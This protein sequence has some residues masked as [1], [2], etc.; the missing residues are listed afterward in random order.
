MNTTVC[1]LANTL[2]Y[3]DGGGGHQWA[4]LNW[5][6]GLRAAGCRVIWMEAVRPDEP[7]HE[8]QALVAH[9]KGRLARYGLADTVA[10]CPWTSEPLL[11]G[12]VHGCLDLDDASEADLLLNLAPSVPAA[13]VGRFRRSAFLDIDPGLTQVWMAQ[14]LKV[15]RHSL[16]F[17][18][19]EGVGQPGALFPDHGL[20][21]H[22]TPPPVCLQAWPVAPA[23]SG[24]PYTSVTHW[25][26]SWIEFEGQVYPNGKREGFLPYLDLP[27]HSRSGL[28]LAAY[29]EDF[30]HERELLLAY[31]WRVRDSHEVAAT[32][33]SYQA[34]L[35]S[36]RGEF[37]CAKPFYVRLQSTWVSDRTVC[38][39]AS[40]KPA[41]VQHTGPSRFLP[42]AEGLFRFRNL[43]EAVKA[44]SS[45]D[46]D[47]AHHCVAAR[48]LAEE[49]FDARRVVARVLERALG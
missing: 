8:V 31:G 41:I 17:T 12:S 4:F 10:L 16:Y 42:D 37:S 2:Y 27:R 7:A 45:A 30:E 43:D 11:P 23:D 14:G 21:W 49:H 32:P 6:L 13:V 20:V 48:R 35:Q 26:D 47:Y 39:L 46:A 28:E 1:L 5:A 9:L 33:W 15:A 34:Y 38:F 29:L 36:A 40:G 22:H 25:G 24:A 19:G 44:M 3:P 18:I